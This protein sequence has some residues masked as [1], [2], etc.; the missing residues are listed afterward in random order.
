VH[1]HAGQGYRPLNGPTQP[2]D[3]ATPRISTATTTSASCVLVTVPQ[4]GHVAADEAFVDLDRTGQRLALGIDHH[5]AV[6]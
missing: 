6:R 3:S 1:T 4:L 2:A 5:P